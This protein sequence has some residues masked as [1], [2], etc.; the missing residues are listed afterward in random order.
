MKRLITAILTLFI[1]LVSNMALAQT[2]AIQQGNQTASS[3][4]NS[5]LS[6]PYVAPMPTTTKVHLPWPFHHSNNNNN[7]YQYYRNRNCFLHM[8][9]F[10]KYRHATISN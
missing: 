6:T 7:S 2:S 3:W 4:N 5:P 8:H 9:M 10:C 1:T